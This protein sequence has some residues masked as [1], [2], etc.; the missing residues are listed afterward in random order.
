MTPLPS[1]PPD[2]DSG[3]RN[4]VPGSQFRGVRRPAVTLTDQ[5]VAALLTAVGTNVKPAVL[6]ERNRAFLVVIWRAGLRLREAL[7]LTPA[8]VDIRQDG[9]HTITVMQGKGAKRRVVGI[10][11]TAAVVLRHWIDVRTKVLGQPPNSGPL[12]CASN[13]APLS[14]RGAQMMLARAAKRAGITKRVTPHALRHTYAVELV[15]EG[16]AMPYI[17]QALGHANLAVTSRYLSGISPGEVSDRLNRR[18]WSPATITAAP[19][20]FAASDK[21]AMIDSDGEDDWYGGR[22]MVA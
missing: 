15:R 21:P 18:S 5:E 4:L 16:I 2:P 22:A 8:D 10:D 3:K 1:P 13:G 9:K 7:S 14:A 6:A 17:Q 20:P 11:A 12:F 19:I